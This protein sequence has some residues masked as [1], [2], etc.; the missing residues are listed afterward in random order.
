MELVYGWFGLTE[1]NTLGMQLVKTLVEQ[2]DGNIVI[3]S[4]NGAKFEIT[5]YIRKQ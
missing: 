4:D 5:F 3:S 2:I 1:P